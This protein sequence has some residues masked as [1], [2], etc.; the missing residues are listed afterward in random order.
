[1]LRRIISGSLNTLNLLHGFLSRDF[2]MLFPGETLITYVDAQIFIVVTAFNGF[3]SDGDT[4]ILYIGLFF[5][6]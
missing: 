6:F 2:C 4:C 1:M 3:S 5:F